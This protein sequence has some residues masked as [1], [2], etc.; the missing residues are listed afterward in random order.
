MNPTKAFKIPVHPKTCLYIERG[1]GA[2]SQFSIEEL[3]LIFFMLL[4][5]ILTKPSIE[6]K[7]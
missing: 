7:G 1:E 5:Y 6:Y 3:L 4:Q 2:L